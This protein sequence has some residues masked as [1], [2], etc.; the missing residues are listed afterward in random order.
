MDPKYTKSSPKITDYNP[1][2]H[3]PFYRNVSESTSLSPVRDE[4]ASFSPQ[5]DP[6]IKRIYRPTYLA[7]KSIIPSALNSIHSK[8]F[9]GLGSERSERSELPVYSKLS[10]KNTIIDPISGQIR[11]YNIRRPRLQYLDNMVRRDKA[12]SDLDFASTDKFERNPIQMRGANN[13][14]GSLKKTVPMVP[15]V[16][17]FAIKNQNEQ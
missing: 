14:S 11:I 6:S 10:I 16:S 8:S 2:T 15:Y 7:G 3:M 1:L 9:E 12:S 13:I 5:K 4:Q 17:Q